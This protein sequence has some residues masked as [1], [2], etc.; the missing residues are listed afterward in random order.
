L[1]DDDDLSQTFN[2]PFRKL[3]A[4]SF[5]LHVAVRQTDDDIIR[6]T[7][8]YLALNFSPNV[9]GNVCRW[10]IMIVNLAV[11]QVIGF[12]WSRHHGVLQDGI[13]ASGQQLSGVVLSLDGASCRLVIIAADGRPLARSRLDNAWPGRLR[14][15]RGDD[16]AGGVRGD[17]CAGG[18]G[19]AKNLGRVGF[20]PLLDAFGRKAA[21]LAQ[22]T[23]DSGELVDRKTIAF[24]LW[25]FGPNQELKCTTF[26]NSLIDYLFDIC[27]RALWVHENRPNFLMIRQ[28]K[29]IIVEA[30]SRSVTFGFDGF[31]PRDTETRVGKIVIECKKL[32]SR[33]AHVLCT[34]QGFLHKCPH[35]L[36]HA[37]SNGRM[38]SCGSFSDARNG[39]FLLLTAT[40]SPSGFKITQCL[41]RPVSKVIS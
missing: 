27:P 21:K 40:T 9:P 38:I 12:L 18:V 29:D 39:T 32:I 26:T 13:S 33:Q 36:F 19:Q 14:Q 22:P 28:G 17:W 15:R 11:D 20:Q 16:V 2:R 5:F 24:A 3:P 7:A 34:V 23:L 41:S 31:H 4:Q 8:L 1:A 25:P 35:L 6:L 37:Y 10:R 30:A